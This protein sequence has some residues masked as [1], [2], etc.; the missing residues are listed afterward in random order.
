MAN[1][2]E[3]NRGKTIAD[4]NTAV[5][6][7]RRQGPLRIMIAGGGTGGHLFPGIAIAQAFTAKDPCNKIVFV[8]TG[9][10]LEQS[11]LS[12]KSFELKQICV[13]GFKQRG[14]VNQV[15]ALLKI[16]I[17]IFQSIRIIKKFKPGLVIGMGSYA[18]GPVAVAAKLLKIKIVLHEQNILP[19]L[20]NRMLAGIADRIYVSF[21]NPPAVF[22]PAKTRITGNP[23]RSGILREAGRKRV[24]KQVFTVLI[25]G[26]SQGAHSINM[27][28]EDALQHIPDPERF[29]FI[30]QTGTK[31]L[32]R[33]T[34]AYRERGMPAKVRAFFSDMAEPYNL[35][36]LIVC[37]AGATT[38]AEV[39]ALGKAVIFIPFPFA[40]DNHQV[41]NA[42]MLSDGRAAETILEKDL[43]GRLLA[44]RIRYYEKKPHQLAGMARRAANLGHPHAA[45]AIVADCYRLLAGL[46]AN[47]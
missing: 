3:L 44:R 33:V 40:A 46:K 32:D 11:M 34:Q 19:G 36:D 12:E 13:E 37:R 9:N 29:F 30:H 23:V 15:K 22:N 42:R 14:V 41:L 16:P 35:A 1:G 39:T 47:S 24:K 20:T 45:E 2:P 7:P 31:D 17:A 10:A 18:A 28:I 27:A 21:E 25:I 6:E 26:G 8:S 4:Q 43:D 38:A 5:I